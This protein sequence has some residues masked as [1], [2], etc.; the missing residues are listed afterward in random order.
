MEG[1]LKVGLT[2]AELIQLASLKSTVPTVKTSRRD[3]AYVVSK[4][5]NGGTTVAGTLIIAK[6]AGIKIFATGG[7]GGV[8]RDG[9]NTM[10]ISADL[11]EM[12][13]SPVAVVSSGIKSI[14]DIGKTMEFLE[15][16]GVLVASYQSENNELPAFYTRSSG[17]K[18]PYNFNTPTEAASMI[19][20]SFDLDLKSG[21]LIAVPVPHEYAMDEKQINEAISN[22]LADAA[23]NDVSGKEITPF[24]LAA[25]SKITKGRSLETSKMFYF[26]PS[27]IKNY[28]GF[29]TFQILH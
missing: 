9:E 16:Q 29:S 2:N 8:H 17:V 15:T 22:A 12:G 14:L 20:T 5:L 6:M 21:I 28:S 10:D 25:V 3:M 23:K 24:I 13:K 26:I 7:I 18:C 11:I 19:N 1:R 4:K 27:Y